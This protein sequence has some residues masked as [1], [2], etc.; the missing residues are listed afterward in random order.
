MVKRIRLTEG[1]KG[2]ILYTL[3]ERGDVKY[4]L[5][6]PLCRKISSARRWDCPPPSPMMRLKKL[7]TNTLERTTSG[8]TPSDGEGQN[9]LQRRFQQSWLQ[10][11][12]FSLIL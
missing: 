3:E 6:S 8:W 2:D 9:S 10:K 4:D 12:T 7:Y 5:L 1:A 11:V